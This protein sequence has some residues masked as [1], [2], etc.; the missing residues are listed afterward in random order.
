MEKVAKKPSESTLLN[1]AQAVLEQGL[2]LLASL[3]K[4][5]KI[6]DHSENTRKVAYSSVTTARSVFSAY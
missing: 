4:L 2:E 5:I 1:K 3:Q 6:P